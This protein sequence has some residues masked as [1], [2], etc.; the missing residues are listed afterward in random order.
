MNGRTGIDEAALTAAH[1]AVE[2]ALVNFRD[3]RIS[4]LNRGNGFVI[5]E[6]DGQQSDILRLGT[7]DGLRIGIAAYLKAMTG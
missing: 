2:D 4:V 7:R 1:K 3:N 5:R 6:R